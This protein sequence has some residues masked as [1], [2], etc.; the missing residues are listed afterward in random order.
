MTIDAPAVRPHPAAPHQAVQA[1]DAARVWPGFVTAIPIE[2]ARRHQIFVYQAQDKSPRFAVAQSTSR[3]AIDTVARRLNILPHIEHCTA[4]DVIRCI[5]KAYEQQTGGAAEL[6][7]SISRSDL[8]RQV[9]QLSSGHDLLEGTTREP[10]VQLV[11]R[12]LFDAVQARASDL[13]IQPFADRVIIRQ[14]I[15]GVLYDAIA[16]PTHLRD[17]LVESK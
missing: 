9:E 5:N 12:V 13:H 15:D 6:M 16:L 7:E 11:N 4:A 3:V 1:I 14:R 10:V 2:F 8:I 17:E